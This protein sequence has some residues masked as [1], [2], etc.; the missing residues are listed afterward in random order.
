MNYSKE[1]VN[2]YDF[3]TKLSLLRRRASDSVSGLTASELNAAARSLEDSIFYLEEIENVHGSLDECISSSQIYLCS[4]RNMLDTRT[5][6]MELNLL[7]DAISDAE[8]S[9]ALLEDI[10]STVDGYK[11]Y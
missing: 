2:G 6:I 11:S 3:L 5:N 8:E 10:R 1:I 7:R 4:L 9:A